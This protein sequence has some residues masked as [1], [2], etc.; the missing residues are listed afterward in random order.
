MQTMYNKEWW[1][2]L[3]KLQQIAVTSASI[4]GAIINAFTYIE[5]LMADIT[6]VID[7][8]SNYSEYYK[9]FKSTTRI[10]DDFFKAYNKIEDLGQKYFT[11]KETL[12]EDIKYL[13]DIRN[14]AAH[15]LLMNN[16]NFLEHSDP[17]Q[18]IYFYSI[19]NSK[20]IYCTMRGSLVRDYDKIVM[21]FVQC[22]GQL[23]QDIYKKINKIHSS[24]NFD[25]QIKSFQNI[26]LKN[27]FPSLK[28]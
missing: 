18:D 11:N 4:R 28:K 27:N 10:V 9:N 21:Q 26:D 8:D 17:F 14:R 7:F 22:F 3:D 1:D 6:I 12:K 20:D 25:E 15:F 2:K 13:A 23:Q 5:S 19:R 16:E 24:K